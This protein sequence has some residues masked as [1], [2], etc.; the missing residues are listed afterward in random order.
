MAKRILIVEEEGSVASLLSRNLSKKGYDIAVQGC[1]Q[2][3][4]RAQ[5]HKP[6]LVILDLSATESSVP[7]A[8]QRL[9][10]ATGAPIIALTDPL[11]KLEELEGV[12]YL[13]KPLDF[14]ELMAVVESTLSRRRKRKR[15]SRRFLRLGDMSL[16]LQNRC[17]IKNEY[18]HHLTPKEFLL[19]KLFMSNPGRVLSHKRIMKEVWNTDYLG[20]TR[21]LYVH[22]SWL[23]RKIEDMPGTPVYL[24]TIR[25]V[26]YRFEPEP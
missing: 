4:Q 1:K 20:D 26:G 15:R 17:L 19:L 8:C 10:D 5:R 11:S 18:R 25:G 6:N 2:A 21:T 13:A 22:V 3:L 7:Q 24:R 12:E 14:R 23:R 16:D 9:S